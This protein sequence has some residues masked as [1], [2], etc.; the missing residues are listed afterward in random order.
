[1]F[2][3][4]FQLSEH[5]RQHYLAFTVVY[6]LATGQFVPPLPRRNLY[7]LQYSMLPARR[8]DI[9]EVWRRLTE[10][11]SAATSN[12]PPLKLPNGNLAR[13]PYR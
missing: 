12:G 9:K 5:I 4:Y 11:R 8:A 7:S 13:R 3:Q 10:Q 1:M 2:D 6:Y